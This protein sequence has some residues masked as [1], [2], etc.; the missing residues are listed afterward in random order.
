[1]RGLTTRFAVIAGGIL[2]SAV[3]LADTLVTKSGSRYEG[4]VTQEGE[5]YVIALDRGG[6][7]SWPLAMVKE[8][9]KGPPSTQP[10][11][12]KSP[13]PAATTKPSS[14]LPLDISWATPPKSLNAWE[15]PAIAYAKL[16]ESFA[17][18]I[19][20]TVRYP[21]EITTPKGVRHEFAV[22]KGPPIELKDK[23]GTIESEEWIKAIKLFLTL[24]QGRGRT[25]MEVA[26]FK[27]APTPGHGDGDRV[28]NWIKI[29]LASKKA[30]P[31]PIKKPE[32]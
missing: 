29:D 13:A 30:P 6:K 8:V 24:G 31:K 17:K 15:A 11:A 16:N 12:T 25:S 5:N 4:V 2:L 21:I 32:A 19:V 9:I 26:L 23:A 14:G 7:Q 22:L 27:E 18:V 10:A 1:M 20:V 3:V 28:S